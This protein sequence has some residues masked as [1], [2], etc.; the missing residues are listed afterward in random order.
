MTFFVVIY[1]LIYKRLMLQLPV[2]Y[3]LF[4]LFFLFFS[5]LTIPLLK[6]SPQHDTCILIYKYYLVFYLFVY[7]NYT[8]CT[9]VRKK[10]KEEIITI[11]L[12]KFKIKEM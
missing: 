4:F 1:T 9:V 11:V 10:R 12:F 2:L 3:L 7:S 8:L 5:R 6:D